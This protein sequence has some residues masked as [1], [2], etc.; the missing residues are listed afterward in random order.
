MMSS[1]RD[2]GISMDDSITQ[3]PE[4]KLTNVQTLKHRFELLCSKQ[5]QN[6]FHL[7]T[8]WWLKEGS[9]ELSRGSIGETETKDYISNEDNCNQTHDDTIINNEEIEDVLLGQSVR[10]IFLMMETLKNNNKFHLENPSS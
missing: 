3:K 7:D 4:C 2:S 1:A 5:K 8:N 9:E 6:E 10:Y